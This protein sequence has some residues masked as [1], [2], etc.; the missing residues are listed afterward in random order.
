MRVL[1]R[2]LRAASASCED[3]ESDCRSA[4]SKELPSLAASCDDFG[5]CARVSMVCRHCENM[6]P[7]VLLGEAIVV[8]LLVVRC[9][10]R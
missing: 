5:E 7:R 4:A 1:R 6:S 3:D 8:F 2:L 9:V 10:G